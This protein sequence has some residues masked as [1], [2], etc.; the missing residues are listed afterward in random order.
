M[1]PYT[2][3]L[4]L[5]APGWSATGGAQVAIMTGHEA[6]FTIYTGPSLRVRLVL[7][8]TLSTANAH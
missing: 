5:N 3:L 1:K 7:K 2:Y 8:T 4:D 6:A